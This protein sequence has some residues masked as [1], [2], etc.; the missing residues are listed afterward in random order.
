[1]GS[2]DE[3][4]GCLI[5]IQGET[6]LGGFLRLDWDLAQEII[7]AANIYTIKKFGPDRLV[8]LPYS[9]LF[10]GFVCFGHPVSEPHRRYGAKLLRFLLRPPPASPQTWGEQTD[11]PESADWYNSS[12]I[13]L[14]GSNV[15]VTAN[16]RSPF[17][18]QVRYKGTKV[19]TI[20]SDYSDASSLP[21]SG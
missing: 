9:G 4:P 21:I 15:P 18:T 8:A 7:S 16:A 12:F 1:M 17:L 13:M 11:V 10:D 20:S 19:V 6:G 2:C 3:R 14:W 5:K